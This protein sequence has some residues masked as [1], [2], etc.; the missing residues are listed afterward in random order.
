MKL[1]QQPLTAEDGTFIINQ[2]TAALAIVT[3]LRKY[4]EPA[5]KLQSA[6]LRQ[7]K[8]AETTI[9]TIKVKPTTS[10]ASAVA[11]RINQAKLGKF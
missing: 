6:E 3:G 8:A 9:Q 7:F 10:R 11:K 4:L 2:L 5:G 1:K